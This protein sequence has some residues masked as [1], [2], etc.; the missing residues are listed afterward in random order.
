LEIGRVNALEFYGEKLRPVDNSQLQVTDAIVA[1]HDVEGHIACYAFEVAA[2]KLKLVASR[3]RIAN[4]T[5][6]IPP[7]AAIGK[8]ES[9]LFIVG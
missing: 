9:V 8:G 6:R 4:P 5:H 1:P 2:I 3:L 7:A